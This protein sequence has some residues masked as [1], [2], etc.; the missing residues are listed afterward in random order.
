MMGK[1]RLTITIG[2]VAAEFLEGCANVSGYLDSLVMQREVQL[3]RD[4]TSL[5]RVGMT[6]DSV[7]SAASEFRSGG[8]VGDVLGGKV[9]EGSSQWEALRRLGFELTGPNSGRVLS[10]VSEFSATKDPALP[11]RRRIVEV[12][13]KRKRS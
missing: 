7:L 5:R 9:R 2:S 10:L 12:T 1:K 6:L 11:A 3:R 13:K 4:V 8:T